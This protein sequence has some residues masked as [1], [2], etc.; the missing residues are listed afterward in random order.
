[1]EKEE[2]ESAATAAFLCLEMVA[3]MFV[4]VLKTD[5]LRAQ[6]AVKT[7]CECRQRHTN[8]VIKEKTSSSNQFPY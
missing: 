1:M 3:V 7:M 5:T 6:E 2:P 4:Y 8:P